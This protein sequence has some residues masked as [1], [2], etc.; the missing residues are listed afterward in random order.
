MNVDEPIPNA[1]APAQETEMLLLPDG[2]VLVHALTPEMDEL[3][4]QLSVPDCF[5]HA[6]PETHTPQSGETP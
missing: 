6:P 5:Y 4:A 1:S 3:L 2:R